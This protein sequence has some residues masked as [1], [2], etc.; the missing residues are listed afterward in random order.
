MTRIVNLHSFSSL[1]TNTFIQCACALCTCTQPAEGTI[2]S[3]AATFEELNL[4]PELL[5]VSVHSEGSSSPM[6]RRYVLFCSRSSAVLPLSASRTLKIMFR[7]LHS[8][9]QYVRSCAPTVVLARCSDAAVHGCT[10]LQGLYVEMKFERPSRIQ[11]STLPMILTPPYKDLI[12]QVRAAWASFC[13]MAFVCV[14]G[15]CL[16]HH[17]SRIL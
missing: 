15:Q 7:H 11:A 5:K 10:H 9:P 12:A 1:H 16:F 14:H 2:Y 6:K 17:A 4:S 8:I 3:S 13:R